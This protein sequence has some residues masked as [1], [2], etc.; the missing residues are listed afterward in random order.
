MTKKQKEKADMIKNEPLKLMRWRMYNYPP[1]E[2]NKHF[3]DVVA[4]TSEIERLRTE[5]NNLNK[6]STIIP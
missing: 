1:I 4:L 6:L 2:L 5:L 3:M